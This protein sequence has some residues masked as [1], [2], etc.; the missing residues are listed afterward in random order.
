L[1]PAK[2]LPVAREWQNELIRMARC[3]EFAGA[4]ST[5][6]AAIVD[7][8]R[9]K[10]AKELDSRLIKELLALHENRI[11]ARSGYEWHDVSANWFR[12]CGNEP[13]LVRPTPDSRNLVCKA[14]NE[15]H[16]D[17]AKRRL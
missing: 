15:V 2:A 12:A 3:L 1:S 5:G 6:R 7:F 13:S 9:R 17:K 10:W 8:L 16:L 11:A 14:R 4:N